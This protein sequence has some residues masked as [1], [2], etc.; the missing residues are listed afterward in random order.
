MISI[1]CI[2]T[3]LATTLVAKP[4]L[5]SATPSIDV[6]CIS[7]IAIAGSPDYRYLAEHGIDVDVYDRGEDFVCELGDGR[8]V[9][10]RGSDEQMRRM[11]SLLDEG[12]LVSSR[13]SLGVSPR[14]ADDDDDDDDDE[15]I[16]QAVDGSMISPHGEDD[17]DSVYLPRGEVVLLP[18]HNDDDREL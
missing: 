7:V 15:T 17:Y 1:T 11:Q 3:A 2:C 18:S 4:I 14:R 13:T 16:I 5:V 9:P 6:G 8:T 10:I 12:E